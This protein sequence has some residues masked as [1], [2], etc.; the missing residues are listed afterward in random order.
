MRLRLH[1]PGASADRLRNGVAAACAVFA[2]RGVD[3][4]HADVGRWRRQLWNLKGFELCDELFDA[5]DAHWADVWHEAEV[6]ALRAAETGWE[7]GQP[8]PAGA[9]LSLQREAPA[10]QST[11]CEPAEAV[12]SWS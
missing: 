12:M 7:P 2:A 1:I 3:P 11:I 9:S 4:Q 10:L 8:W 5:Q 6:A